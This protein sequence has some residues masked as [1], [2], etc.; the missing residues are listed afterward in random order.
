MLLRT[1]CGFGPPPVHLLGILILFVPFIVIL[2]FV[3][4]YYRRRGVRLSRV[5]DSEN[6]YKNIDV[7]SIET[8]TQSNDPSLLPIK[9]PI[10]RMLT[11]L[12]LIAMI[13]LIVFIPLAEI[14]PMET[15]NPW[16]FYTVF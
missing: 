1:I 14:I 3:Q 6:G 11:L 5:L 9:N 2:L 4:G 10:L 7:L 16:G 8:Q 12:L 15:S 13:A